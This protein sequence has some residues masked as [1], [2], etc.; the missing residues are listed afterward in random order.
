MLTAYNLLVTTLAFHNLKINQKDIE[1][2]KQEGVYDFDD[3]YHSEG[4]G[5]RITYCFAE[6]VI[7]EWVYEPSEANMTCI[8]TWLKNK[9]LT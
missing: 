8:L 7:P 2:F 1:W 6:Q 3:F 9:G 5:E 4:P